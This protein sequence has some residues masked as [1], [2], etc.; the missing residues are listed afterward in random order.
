MLHSCSLSS[1]THL[2]QHGDCHQ[3][4]R[5]RA[6]EDGSVGGAAP[7]MLWTSGFGSGL[8]VCVDVGT[9]L[10]VSSSCSF[11]LSFFLCLDAASRSGLS[12]KH[13][14]ETGAEVIDPDYRYSALSLC[15][16]F[17]SL[18]FTLRFFL[19]FYNHVFMFSLLYIY[20]FIHFDV[21]S[22][23]HFC[24]ACTEES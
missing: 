19:F 14:L 23:H 18:F 5:P 1:A 13:G 15:L 16:S 9:V 8:C 3:G 4:T 7:R 10:S 11:F 21:S 12:L 20:T 2:Q 17:Y 6:C 22:E 24:N